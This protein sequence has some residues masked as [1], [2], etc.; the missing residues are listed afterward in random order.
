MIKPDGVARGLVAKIIKR[1]EQRGYKLVAMK[2]MKASE[3]LLKNHYADLSAKPFFS[4][5]LEFVGSGPVVAMVWEGKDVVKQG[6]SMLGET[7]PLASKPG[8]I[9]GDYSIDIGRNII[10]GSDSIESAKKEISLW[11]NDKELVE[12]KPPCYSSI[13]E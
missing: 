13:Y 12:W 5:L 3:E 4:K 7:N 1:F 10:H 9:R 11:F 2:L 6:R 8:S